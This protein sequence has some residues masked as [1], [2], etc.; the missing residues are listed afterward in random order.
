MDKY[1]QKSQY[2]LE[3][4][5]DQQSGCMASSLAGNKEGRMQSAV[6]AC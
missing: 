6:Y 4:V 3:T 5:G 2:G 1:F